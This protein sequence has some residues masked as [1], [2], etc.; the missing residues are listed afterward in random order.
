MEFPVS[1]PA[2]SRSTPD[3]RDN[4]E[5]PTR[6]LLSRDAVPRLVSPWLHT[7]SVIRLFRVKPRRV[8][9]GGDCGEGRT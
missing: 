2:Q 5:S 8:L 7:G 4:G 9:L 1:S 6:S 3:D